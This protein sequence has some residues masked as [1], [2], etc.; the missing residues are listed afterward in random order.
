MKS[1]RHMQDG[2]D[3]RDSD[4]TRESSGETWSDQTTGQDDNNTSKHRYYGHT[5]APVLLPS[6]NVCHRLD[7]HGFLY[8]YIIPSNRIRNG[9]YLPKRK[10]IQ[11]IVIAKSCHTES[12][13]KLRCFTGWHH[14][15]VVLWQWRPAF[16]GYSRICWLQRAT[17]KCQ[18]PPD[19]AFVAWFQSEDS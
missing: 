17:A 18:D 3:G 2:W 1:Q 6:I 4:L 11:C 13:T 14:E 8:R 19:S 12:I 5:L 16:V 9:N 7:P 15:I 10:E